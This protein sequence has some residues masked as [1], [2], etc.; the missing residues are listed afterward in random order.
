M[1]SRPLLARPTA[2]ILPLKLH[3]W[4]RRRP[5]PRRNQL[6]CTIPL[7][8]GLQQLS[9]NRIPR[10]MRAQCLRVMTTFSV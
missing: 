1:L 4:C 7:S 3:Q 9:S 5:S 6:R 10:M 8:I 2:E